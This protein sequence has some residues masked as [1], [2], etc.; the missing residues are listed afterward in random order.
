[1]KSLSL[2]FF[3]LLS[4]SAFAD[5]QP[6][7]TKYSASGF[8]PIEWSRSDKCEVFE[9]EVLLTRTYARSA[10]QYRIPFSAEDSLNEMIA[11]AQV[12]RL[13]LEDNYMCDGPSTTIKARFVAEGSEESQEILLYSTGGCGSPKK[14]RV[15]PAS[16]ALIDIASTFCPTTH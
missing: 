11:K 6:F 10:V 15:G 16:S 9:T 4:F 13:K 1:M 7:I 5:Q 8:V 3:G 12:E 14:V 2:V